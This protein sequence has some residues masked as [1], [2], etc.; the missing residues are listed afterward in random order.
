MHAFRALKRQPVKN[1]DPCEQRDLSLA[2]TLTAPNHR[3]L[4]KP[5]CLMDLETFRR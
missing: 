5:R 1:R 2:R 4:T 3:R